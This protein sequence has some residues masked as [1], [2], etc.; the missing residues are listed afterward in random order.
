MTQVP[1]GAETPKPPTRG[2]EN[3]PAVPDEAVIDAASDYDGGLRA[4]AEGGR[5]AMFRNA[6]RRAGV[7]HPAQIARGPAQ[8][9][10]EPPHRSTSPEQPAQDIDSP[11]LGL[12]Y[13]EPSANVPGA[14]TGALAA[15]SPAS[16][17]HQDEAARQA[18]APAVTARVPEDLPVPTPT[19][20]LQHAPRPSGPAPAQPDPGSPPPA[21]ARMWNPDAPPPGWRPLA[22]AAPPVTDAAPSGAGVGAGP[23]TASGET[24]VPEPPP[25]EPG[26]ASSVVSAPLAP[27]R[28]VP[29]RTAAPA[30]AQPTGGTLVPALPFGPAP[31]SRP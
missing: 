7:R 24:A 11:F 8:A 16:S 9:D 29:N 10:A 12:F 1:P 18:A 17:N 30:P 14:A 31:V 4:A 28:S 13:G 27:A 22:Q 20:T 26:G 23:A 25:A 19:A 2:G 5:V 21:P 3:R 15:L 6:G